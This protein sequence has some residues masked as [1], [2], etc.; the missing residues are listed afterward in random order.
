MTVPRESCRTVPDHSTA[1]RL[2]HRVAPTSFAGSNE[3]QYCPYYHIQSIKLPQRHKLPKS[4]CR[5]MAARQEPLK[6]C[7]SG[8]LHQR[9][10]RLCISDYSGYVK[11]QL[12]SLS[13]NV[14]RDRHVSY[15][16]LTLYGLT[17]AM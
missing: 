3:F 14:G 10:L 8:T 11:H 9:N 16:H 5:A 15:Y 2:S 13:L 6:R 17:Y 7:S 4:H 1:N 12:K